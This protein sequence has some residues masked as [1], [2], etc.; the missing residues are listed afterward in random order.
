[1]PVGEITNRGRLAASA[2][3]RA[4]KRAATAGGDVDMG[5]SR[6]ALCTGL[7]SAS[8]LPRL[9]AESAASLRR[10]AWIDSC[11]A[12][13]S[14]KYDWRSPAAASTLLG[15]GMVEER[16]ATERLGGVDTAGVGCTGARQRAAVC[17][18][19]DV[20]GGVPTSPGAAN[21]GETWDGCR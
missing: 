17:S 3:F 1:M 16:E 6:C 13:I 2:S 7:R 8:K 4:Q 11:R 20:V 10:S 5:F 14:R 12:T 18:D 19:S 21:V 15:I 9:P